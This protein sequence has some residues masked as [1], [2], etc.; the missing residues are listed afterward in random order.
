MFEH[1]HC[2]ADVREIA[3]LPVDN[4][5][6]GRSHIQAAEIEVEVENSRR[7]PEDL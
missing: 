4:L 1:Q 7:N 2:I 3:L 6:V 5:A